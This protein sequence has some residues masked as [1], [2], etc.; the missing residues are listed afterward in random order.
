V[1]GPKLRLEVRASSALCVRC[2]KRI[3]NLPGDANG[4]ILAM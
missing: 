3:R 1:L 4:L 2:F